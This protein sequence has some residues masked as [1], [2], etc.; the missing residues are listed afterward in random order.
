MHYIKKREPLIQHRP[1]AENVVDTEKLAQNLSYQYFCIDSVRFIK[2]PINTVFLICG[3]GI[4]PQDFVENYQIIN[5]HPGYIPYSRGLDALK[6]AIY[7]QQ[8]IGVTTHLLG[9][10]VDAGVIL[11]R[12]LVPIKENDTF[13]TVAQRQYELEIAMLV[14]AISLLGEKHEN[15]LGGDFPIHKRMPLEKERLLYER[16]QDYMSAQKTKEH[17]D[18]Q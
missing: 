14:D 13:H 6:W 10:E 11:Q 17:E 16:F 12:K 2:E 5:A 4:L 15:V 3:A 9:E 1:T 7:E 18:Q 8:P